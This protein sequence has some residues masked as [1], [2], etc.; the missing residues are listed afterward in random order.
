MNLLYLCSVY[1]SVVCQAPKQREKKKE[2]ESR[3]L[4]ETNTNT[5]DKISFLCRCFSTA[6]RHRTSIRSW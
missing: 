5:L 2:Y 4:C 1:Y 3:Q 6:A